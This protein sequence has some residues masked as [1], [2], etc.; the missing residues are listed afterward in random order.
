MKLASRRL[1]DWE[2]SSILDAIANTTFHYPQDIAV[3][4]DDNSYTYRELE[5]YSS[6][7]ASRLLKMNFKHGESVALCFDKS[8]HAIAAMLGAYKVGAAFVPLDPTL[9]ADRI[10]FMIE[11]ASVQ[12]VLCAPQYVSKFE[13]IPVR[14]AIVNELPSET[15][16]ISLR[17][18]ELSGRDRAYIMYTSGSTGK[19]KGVPVSHRALLNYC[20][21]DNDIYQLQKSDRTLQFSTLSFDIAIEEIFP[22][23]MTGSTVVVRPSLRS[24]AQIELSE[25]V[26]TYGITALHLATGYWHEWVDLMIAAGAS[27]PETIRL[28]VVTGEKVSPEHYQRWQTLCDKPTLWAN[29]YGPTEATVTATVFVPPTGWQGKTLPIGKPILNYTAYILND[30]KIPVEPGETGEL[31]IGGPGLADGYLNRPELTEKAFFPDPFSDEASALMYRTGD[32]ARWMS[33]GNIEYAGRIDHQIKIGS[34]RIEPGEI[35]NAI[36][37]HADVKDT[38]VIADEVND[39]K[40]LLTY[41]AS[42]NPELTASALSDFLA[43]SLPAYMIPARYVFLRRLP[44]TLNG[45]IDRKALPDKSLAVTPTDK[46]YKAPVGKVQEQLCAIWSNILGVPE[47]GSDSSFISLGGDSL[48]AVKTISRIQ[49]DM[50][51]TISTRDFFHLDTVAQLAGYIEGKPV[52]RVAPPPT[53]EYINTR[54]RQLY[55][56]LQTP[57]S[58]KSNGK[59]LLIVPPVG[60]EQRRTQ[61]PF[62]LLMQNLAKQG[63]TTLRFD[64]TGTGNSSA[65]GSDVTSLSLWRA[66]IQDAADKLLEHCSVVDMVAVRAGALIAANTDLHPLAVRRRYYWDPVCS[67][68]QWLEEM[69]LLQHRIVSDSYRFLRERKID[70]ENPAEFAGLTLNTQ[71]QSS[72]IECDMQAMLSEHSWNA[73]SHLLLAT[74]DVENK[75]NDIS[76]TV[77]AVIDENDWTNERTTTIDMRINDAASLVTELLADDSTVAAKT[78]APQAGATR[79]TKSQSSAKSVAELCLPSGRPTAAQLKPIEFV[80]TFGSANQFVGVYTPPVN[81]DESSPCVLYITAGLLHHVGPTRLHVELA[82]SLSRQQV[83]GFR[84]DLSGIGESETSSMGGYFT[85]RSVK[86]IQAAMDYIQAAYQHDE[87]VLLGLC[88]GADDAFATAQQDNR[89]NGLVLLNGY[90]YPAGKF[91]LYRFKEFYLPRL[92]MINKWI[93]TIKRLLKRTSVESTPLETSV[94]TAMSDEE[95]AAVIALDDDYRYIPSQETTESVIDS[96]TKRGVNM[97]F[98][99]N[100]SEHDAY[101]Y[102]GQLMDMFPK[103][104]GNPRMQEDYIKEADHTYILQADRDKLN[105]L[106]STWFS[107]NY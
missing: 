12:A 89:V 2:Y 65:H 87:F 19:P 103:Q 39:K 96:L 67:G 35:E 92:L 30:K 104:R 36:N 32:L 6:F 98:I 66:D 54:G 49:S 27:V 56:V 20:I 88:S 70:L 25:I 44:K 51:F 42:D 105:D 18:K 8:I 83:A 7:I 102:K 84:F 22:P 69:T 53:P 71:L 78:I 107:K 38:L 15:T 57:V 63:Y 16:D 75:Y 41:I 28:M 31:Y 99:Y 73:G 34:Y 90:A 61:R 17:R 85:E 21:A 5:I 45:K 43:K 64:W 9:P 86:E 26:S 24:D 60:N 1:K 40:R 3:I 4:H 76:C 59:G 50:G 100:G 72:L 62:R 94:S 14:I 95:R 13:N 58:E 33:D 29:A 106:L 48:L 68:K 52:G 74:S 55:T 37:E 10:A 81:A 91:K 93:N 23:L 79:A 47:I 11:D 101:T 46:S 80:Q 82:R 97:Y 77:H